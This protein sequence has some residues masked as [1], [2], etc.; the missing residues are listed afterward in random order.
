MLCFLG[1]SLDYIKLL[2][3]CSCF[4]VC[5]NGYLMPKPGKL[6]E[7]PSETVKVRVLVKDKDKNTN[8]RLSQQQL[9]SNMDIF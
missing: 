6:T 5:T 7:H 4:C 1:F 2:S 3:V 8:L 9:A